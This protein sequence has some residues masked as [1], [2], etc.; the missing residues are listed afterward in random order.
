[1]IF[2]LLWWWI[3]YFC[4]KLLSNLRI[5]GWRLR[6][7]ETWFKSWWVSYYFRGSFGHAL[8]PK[9]KALKENLEV[10]NKGFL[11]CHWK[12]QI[13]FWDCKERKGSLS[14]ELALDEFNLWLLEETSWWL[15]SSE[16]SLNEGIW[17]LHSSKEWLMLSEE[18]TTL[19]DS[20]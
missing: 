4:Y 5:C 19:I 9:L 1:M 7:F 13:V 20:Q 15:K 8:I 17:M 18:G 6:G 11:G 14:L 3:G 12:D 16:L 10:W 2:V